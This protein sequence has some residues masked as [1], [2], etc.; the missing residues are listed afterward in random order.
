MGSNLPSYTIG[1][2]AFSFTLHH[3]EGNMPS[4]LVFSSPKIEGMLSGNQKI[5]GTAS[6]HQYSSQTKTK[7]A[8]LYQFPCAKPEGG[9]V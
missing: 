9:R 3:H 5:P 1:I 8:L 4:I 2:E 7:A 6:F